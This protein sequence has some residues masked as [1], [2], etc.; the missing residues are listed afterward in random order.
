MSREPKTAMTP[1]RGELAALDEELQVVLGGLRHLPP[2]DDLEAW[3]EHDRQVLEARGAGAAEERLRATE[4]RARLLIAEGFPDRAMST[5]LQ[6]LL[7]RARGADLPPPPAAPPAADVVLPPCNS[8]ALALARRWVRAKR[9]ILVISGPPGVG[10]TV[11]ACAI[12]LAAQR[13]RWSFIRSTAF[14]A[15]SRYERK[16]RES[17]LGGALLLDD[18]GAEYLDDKGSL[19]TDLDELVDVYYASARPLVITTNIPVQDFEA[20]YQ[21]LRMVSRLRE[22][23]L[24]LEAGPEAVCLRPSRGGGS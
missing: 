24:W 17:I 6:V 19:M 4:R 15:S 20:R 2:L 13:E 9:N 1:R 7:A 5:A 14:A 22:A 10:K 23:A 11:A 18:L 3:A 16:E 12:A 21:S 8:V